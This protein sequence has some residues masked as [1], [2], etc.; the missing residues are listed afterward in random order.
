MTTPTEHERHCPM[1]EQCV[2]LPLALARIE[3]QLKTVV[4]CQDRMATKIDRI[5]EQL[6]GPSGYAIRMDRVEGVIR[7]LKW[8]TAST[9]VAV[10]TLIG[11]IIAIRIDK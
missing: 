5:R 8:V 11:R 7:V 3:E 2:S 9:V 10:L 6:E 4:A 1:E